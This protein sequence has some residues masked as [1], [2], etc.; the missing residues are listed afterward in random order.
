[1]PE[2]GPLPFDPVRQA[3]DMLRGVAYQLSQ[4]VLAWLTIGPDEVLF[5]EG[6]E[7]FDVVGP[8]E[9]RAVQVFD[10]TRRITLRTPKVLAA[11]SNF[12][13]L[14]VASSPSKVKFHFLSRAQATVEEGQ[15][16]GSGI[17][18]L[19]LWR[20]RRPDDSQVRLLSQFLSEQM[21]LPEG[22]REFLRASSLSTLRRDFLEAVVWDLGSP[23]ASIVERV[24]EDKL[25]ILGEPLGLSFS[26]AA[27][28]RFRLFGEVF[29]V[30]SQRDSVRSLNR[31][32]LLKL[33]EDEALVRVPRSELER[34]KARLPA[35]QEPYAPSAQ[36]LAELQ[37]GAPPMPSSAAMRQDLVAR[38]CLH[39]ETQ[40][41]L[42]LVGS[43]GMGKTTLAKLLVSAQENTWRWFS[44]TGRVPL[45]VNRILRDL[46]ALIDREPSISSFVLDDLDLRPESVRIIEEALAALICRLELLRGRLITTSQKP[47]GPRMIANGWLPESK[48]FRVPLLQRDEIIEMAQTLG[49]A[50]SKRASAWATVCLGTTSGHPQLS[51]AFLTAIRDKSWPGVSGAALANVPETMHEHH[52]AARQL[53][54]A[55]P[56]PDRELIYRLSLITRAFRRD[57][58]VDLGTFPPPISSPGASLDRLR[59]CWIDSLHAGYYRVSPLLTE[60]AAQD[61]PLDRVRELHVAIANTMGRCPPLT[62]IEAGTAFRHAWLARSDEIL[63]GLAANFLSDRESFEGIARELIWFLAEGLPSG[64]TL[65]PSRPALSNLLRNLQARV[66]ISVSDSLGTSIFDAWHEELFESEPATSLMDKMLLITNAL[67]FYQVRIPAKRIVNYFVLQAEAEKTIPDFPLTEIVDSPPVIGPAFAGVTDPIAHVALMLVP[68]C[69]DMTFVDELLTALDTIPNTLRERIFAG[70]RKLPL[71]LRM[72]IDKVWLAESERSEPAWTG[73]LAL[74]R[75]ANNYGKKWSIPELRVAAVK[76]TALVRDEYLH[77]QNGALSELDHARD[78]EHLDSYVLDDQRASTLFHSGRSAEALEIWKNAFDRW[79]DAAEP[80]DTTAGFSARIAGIAAAGLDDWRQ[81]AFWFL[82]GL[83]KTPTDDINLPLRVGLLTDAAFAFWRASAAGECVRAFSEALV[84]VDNLPAGKQ[85][86]SCF[87]ARKNFGHV[88]MWVDN[89]LY[90]VDRQQF[91]EPRAGFCSNPETPEKIRELPDSDPDVFPVM[92]LRIALL[93][94]QDEDVFEW[95]HPRLELIQSV[96]PR[97]FYRDTV[98]RRALQIAEVA[99]L[100]RLADDH[101]HALHEARASLSLD[102][103]G[104]TV[105]LPEQS[106]FPLNDGLVGATLFLSAMVALAGV[107]RSCLE[108]ITVWRINARTVAAHSTI[109]EWLDYADNVL[110]EDLTISEATLQT[111][112]KSR[113]EFMLAALHLATASE[114]SPVQLLRAHCFLVCELPSV[115]W[116]LHIEDAFAAIVA[117]GWRRVAQSPFRLFNPRAGLPSLQQELVGDSSGAKKAARII[118]AAIPLV[119]LRVHHQIVDQIKKRAGF[120]SKPTDDG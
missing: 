61:L 31:A 9:A 96:A 69:D 100:P 91:V 108:S 29:K 57:H 73:C 71:E 52:T 34:L 26:E 118:L 4:S 10:T 90:G 15:P 21:A 64:L 59:D 107:G 101:L 115:P 30:A 56:E 112:G 62:W 66:A 13:K 106:A 80:H 86:L 105:P 72:I 19:D 36:T 11:I 7:D 51:R 104:R 94:G 50:D 20:Q 111:G 43:A 47:P 65:Y 60:A 92:L 79:P 55:L 44:F 85:D 67:V 17:A 53:V 114:S 23:D 116:F 42:A 68:R 98:L 8:T 40:G 6:A 45:Q 22:L 78:V 39:I 117:N 89:T 54:Q 3:T 63:T 48:T 38:L 120:D 82:R 25:A 76:A 24:V 74:F 75:K 27:K 41:V 88:L 35:Q 1:M 37:V 70:L 77:D 16:F 12:W 99:D 49:C 83:E 2:I 119:D 110:G 97:V 18:G 14:S 95:L 58:A 28:I 33:V 103:P 102:H 113:N 81:A 93:L 84:L 32:Q 87:K 109:N 46:T 5:L